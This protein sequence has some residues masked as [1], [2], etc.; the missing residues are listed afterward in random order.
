[1][2]EEPLIRRR[3]YELICKSPGIH[4]R[5]LQRKLGIA[6]GNLQYHLDRLEELRLVKSVKEEG[7]KRYYVT[8]LRFSNEEKKIMSALR[9]RT[10][11]LI[12]IY[13]LTNPFAS[14]KELSKA[15]NLSPS[16]ISWHISKLVK[17]GI[18]EKVRN[19][20]QITLRIKDSE[21]VEKMLITY[22]ETLIDKLVEKFVEVWGPDWLKKEPSAKD[23]K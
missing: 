3:I 22:R 12:L 21:K 11:K 6:V 9:T 8:S 18:I 17:L 10:E 4:F 1:M 5:E 16:T 2:N 23:M 15:L 14:G 13:L 19:K 20:D 7:Y